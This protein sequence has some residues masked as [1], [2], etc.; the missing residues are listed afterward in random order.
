MAEWKVH[1]PEAL[2]AVL[3]RQ[4]PDDTK[5]VWREMWVRPDAIETSQ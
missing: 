1:Q 5:D 2:I 3:A 4:I